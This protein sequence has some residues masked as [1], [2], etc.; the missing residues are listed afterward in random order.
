M[1]HIRLARASLLTFGDE[2]ALSVKVLEGVGRVAVST[3]HHDGSVSIGT[4]D[5]ESVSDQNGTAV[6]RF[7]RH[8][9]GG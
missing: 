7:W 9:E 5:Q 8:R 3:L 1:R 4:R 2:D 6:G